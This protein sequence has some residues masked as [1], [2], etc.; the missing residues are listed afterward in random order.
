MLRHTSELELAGRLLLWSLRHGLR[1]LRRR[2]AL[3]R[4]VAH[5]LCQLSGDERLLNFTEDLLAHLVLGARH[6]LHL[7][8]PECP[9]L[10][11]DE[12]HVVMALIAAQ[13][14]L[15][16]DIRHLLADLQH[17]GGLDRSAAACSRVAAQLSANELVMAPIL[18]A[19]IFA[20]G[21]Q[22]GHLADTVSA[23]RS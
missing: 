6:P 15:E 8:C 13:I 22:T 1:C 21:I 17:A 9:W 18:N 4:F 19:G 3:P 16:S 7:A 23:S 20:P 11:Q 10:T 12:Q 5:T 2:Q 14:G